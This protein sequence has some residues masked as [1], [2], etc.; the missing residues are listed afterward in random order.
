MHDLMFWDKSDPK[1]DYTTPED[2][3]VLRNGEMVPDKGLQTFGG[4]FEG[5][6]LLFQQKEYEKAEPIF[7]KIADHKKNTLRIMEE[8]RYYQAECFYK[9]GQYPGAAD[10]YMQ[11]LSNF[12]S[13]AHG[14]EARKRLFDIANYWLDETRAQMQQAR[15]R[16]D[17]KRWITMPI[18]PVH[19]ED[20]K[21]LL[22]IEGHAVRVLEAVYMTDPRGP[23][24]E[25]ALFFLGSVKFYRESYRDAEDHFNQLVRN[26]PNGVH[27]P[28]AL[29][30]AIICM[31]LNTN[32]PDHDGKRL[33][34]ARDLI[35][36]ATRTYPELQRGQEQFLAKQTVAINNLQAEKDFNIARYFERTGH[37][38]SAHFYYEIVQRR[39]PGTTWAEKAQKKV[40]ELRA[41]AQKQA[42]SDQPQHPTAPAGPEVGPVPRLVG[43]GQPVPPPNDPA[44]PPRQLPPG[45][46]GVR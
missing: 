37:P 31:E 4:D 22:D 34:Q 7:G 11:L 8:A 24:G 12:P 20:S 16:A 32:G 44:S 29:Q 25:K 18:Q 15:E 46:D 17:G 2:V 41:T 5:A 19:W 33:Q 45:L 13:A 39:Y 36:M 30:M 42:S 21:P 10:R 1:I 28:K 43:P 38:G 26:Y 23:L 6:R 3:L 40:I 14:D 35:D 27:A 9:R